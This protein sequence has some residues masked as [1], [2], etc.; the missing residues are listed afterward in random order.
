MLLIKGI[1]EGIAEALENY[2][3]K[4]TTSIFNTLL[5]EV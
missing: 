4:N 2:W 1:A 5:D 3:C